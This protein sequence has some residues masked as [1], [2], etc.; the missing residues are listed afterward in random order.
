VTSVGPEPRTLGPAEHAAGWSFSDPERTTADLARLRSMWATIATHLG[1]APP[2]ERWD[3]PDG[4]SH[5]L[6]V[7]SWADLA[8]TATPAL[9][10]FFGQARDVD[11]EPIVALE[12]SLVATV[13]K[14]AGFLVYY[15]LRDPH[16]SNGNLV[17]FSSVERKRVLTDEPD[18]DAAIARVAIH[19]DSL[20][21][22]V[23]SIGPH[24]PEI[25]RTRYMAF[26]DGSEAWRAVRPGR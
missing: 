11:H 6:V 18:H 15:T 9:V 17:L 16:G 22:H 7:S 1:S 10:G 5:W 12:S 20:R 26:P 4:S 8:A 21:L 23:G 14:S 19:Y 13:R 2:P 3:A 25:E 24:G